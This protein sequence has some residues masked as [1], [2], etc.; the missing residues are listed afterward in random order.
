MR[1]GRDEIKR[2]L[3]ITLSNLGDVILTTPVVEVL[4]REFKGAKLDVM[5]GPNGIEVFEKH[6]GVSE[7]IVYDKFQSLPK[8]IKLISRLRRKH[9][10]LIV[11]LRNTFMP[12]FIGAPHKSLPFKRFSR[13]TAHKKNVHLWKLKT[14]GINVSDAPCRL[15]V[16]GEDRRYVDSLLKYMPRNKLVTINAGAKSHMKRWTKEGFAYTVNRLREETGAGIVMIGSA[17]EAKI[18]SDVLAGSGEGV[19]NLVG[20]TTVRQLI[21]LLER[22]DLLI[23]NDSAPLHIGSVLGKR[24]LAIFGPTD[25][26]EYGPFSKGSIA[27]QKPV[28]CAPCRK[29]HCAFNYEC[30]RLLK[31][32]RVFETA[33]ALL[34]GRQLDRLEPKRI[35][36]AR[37]D[38]IGDVTLSTPAVKAIYETYPNSFISFMVQPYAKGVVKGNPYLDE[39]IVFDKKR[40]HRGILGMFKFVRMLKARRFD[41]AV[42]LHPTIRVHL[43]VF[44]AG[45]PERIGYRKKMGFLLTKSIPH[46]KQLGKKHEAE[47]TLDVL[48]P[49]GIE[50]SDAG[51]FVPVDEDATE[52]VEGFLSS[53]GIDKD[54]VIVG[55]HPG[56]SCPSKKW[57]FDRFAALADKI[58]NS[59]DSKVVMIAG[60]SDMSLGDKAA[61]LSKKGVVNLAGT[62]SIRELAAF[63]KRCS[64]FISNDSGPVHIAVAVG[65]PVISIFGRNEKGLSPKRWRPLGK[66]DI[67]IHK[68]VGC[69]KCLAHNCKI[70][71]KCLKQIDVDEVLDAVRKFKDRLQK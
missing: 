46:D 2:I 11:D 23:T 20:K 10:S 43:A 7:L 12:Y 42:I 50:G 18:S 40:L 54:D 63:L 64:L 16:G 38:R 34:E 71:F 65:T 58:I 37:T 52:K 15:Y 49:L 66:D 6:P 60:P 68:D 5:V 55:I 21:A 57:P 67:V 44:L 9:Y 26:V 51:L 41:V 14:L 27:L 36:I 48:R 45:I 30:M 59:F 24:I 56:A 28:V 31:P 62:L 17:D 1:L 8:K 39:V 22:T 19:L 25:P 32:E 47:Y 70:G 33:K 69:K 35:L 29:A 4:L 61:S 3:V 53:K 13:H